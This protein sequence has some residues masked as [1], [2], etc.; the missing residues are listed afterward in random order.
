MRNW[1][2]QDIEVGTIVG[3]GTKQ[4]S[5]SVFQVGEV[6]EIVPAKLKARVAWKFNS[7]NVIERLP[8]GT[9]ANGQQWWN[10]DTIGFYPGSGWRTTEGGNGNLCSVETLFVLPSD[11]LFKA[12]ALNALGKEFY[13]R[14]KG[15]N[16]MSRQEWLDRSEAL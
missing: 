16:P 3:R 5:T 4:S 1:L 8:G 6:T 15:G 10:S 12:E 9:Y 11:T 14:Q 13:D 2:G 7:S